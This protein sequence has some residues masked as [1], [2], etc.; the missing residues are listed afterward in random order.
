MRKYAYKIGILA[1][2][3]YWF[4]FRPH[5]FGVKCVIEGPDGRVLMIRHTYGRGHWNF[6]GGRRE[7]DEAPANAAIREVNE[8]L[9]MRLQEVHRLE[10]Y[11][12]T[13]EY[14]NDHIDVFVAS[15]ENANFVPNTH[16]VREAQWADPNDPPQPMGGVAKT[17]LNLFLSRSR[18]RRS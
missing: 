14:K 12:S 13:L 5:E 11:V 15:V 16:E 8:E 7:K 4:L 10:S 1:M 3:L 17:C 18:G 9:G 6:P 2:K